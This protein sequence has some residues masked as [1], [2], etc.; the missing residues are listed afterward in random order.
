M[1][2]KEGSKKSNGTDSPVTATANVKIRLLMASK[3]A[4]RIIGKGGAKIKSFREQSTARINISDGSLPERIVTVNGPIDAVC[5]AFK[6]ICQKLDEDFRIINNSSKSEPTIKFDLLIPVPHCRS[7][8]GKGGGTVKEIRESTGAQVSIASNVLPNSSDRV[9]TI[10]GSSS[11]ISKCIQRLSQLLSELPLGQHVPY[12]PKPPNV[13]PTAFQNG[14]VH[15]LTFAVPG[16]FPIPPHAQLPYGPPVP[17]I[18]Q[19]APYS[20]DIPSIVTQNFSAMS[21]GGTFARSTQLLKIPHDLIGC[22]IGRGGVK[23]NEIRQIS[24]ANIK[25]ASPNGD[26]TGRQVTISGTP[27]SISAA[28]YLISQRIYHEVHK[29]INYRPVMVPIIQQ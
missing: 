15:E 8:I 25:I 10:T 20:V 14:Q 3:E 7:I 29:P 17:V 28:Q 11:A 12:Q 24:G 9:M 5:K 1:P 18:T 2:K 27:E 13:P 26:T 19:I 4:G 6:L 23:I 21:N 16:P 22:I